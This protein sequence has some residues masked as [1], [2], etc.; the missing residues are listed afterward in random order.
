MQHMPR[1]N[2]KNNILSLAS[3]A[4]L[5]RAGQWVLLVG[6]ALMLLVGGEDNRMLSRLQ[7]QLMGVI[8]PVISVAAAPFDAMGRAAT[9]V[10]DWMNTYRNN[11]T[12]KAENNTLLQWQER[13]QQLQAENEALKKLL[14]FVPTPPNRFL[15][16]AIVADGTGSLHHSALIAAGSDANIHTDQAVISDQGLLGRI[17]EVSDRHS[18]VMLLT[19]LNSRIPVMN[20]RTR[21]KM[22]LI[23]KGQDIPSLGYLPTN[24]KTI[25]GDRLITSGDGGVFPKA[26]PVG[27]ISAMTASTNAVELFAHIDS[28]E[29][30][31]IIDATPLA[32]APK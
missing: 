4:T 20:E 30:V 9:G 5:S 15:S 27:R 19:D 11:Q 6:F 22:I 21:E 16:A 31:S 12:L 29:Y 8:T 10:A 13:A 17:V 24:H 14:A 1:K 28:T 18:R 25:A 26:I 23:G 7:S 2:N 32:A 3:R